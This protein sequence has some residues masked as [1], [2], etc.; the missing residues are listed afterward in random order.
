[1][2]RWTGGAA[3]AVAVAL[4]V[5]LTGCTADAPPADPQ[6]PSAIQVTPGP[7]PPPGTTGEPV[8]GVATLPPV[9]VGEP[10]PFGDVALVAR[11]VR[12]DPVQLEAN[13][14]G[15]VAGPGVSVTVELANDGPE[16]IDLSGVAVNGYY[17]DGVPAAASSADPAAPATGGLPPGGTGSGVYAFLVPEDGTGSFVVEVNYSGSAN[18]V[19]VRS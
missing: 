3:A 2:T 15:E 13:G 1:M 5:G 16:P 7:P 6:G 8:A 4:A 12:I 11:V 14:P 17:G 9:P 18:V 10:A 19:L